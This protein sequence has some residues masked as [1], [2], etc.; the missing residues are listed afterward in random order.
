[1]LPHSIYFIETIYLR[2]SDMSSFYCKLQEDNFFFL[3]NAFTVITKNIDQNIQ[4]QDLPVEFIFKMM[5]ISQRVMLMK[6]S[7]LKNVNQPI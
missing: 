3:L 5:Q 1:M 2:I 6:S 4:N 7:N